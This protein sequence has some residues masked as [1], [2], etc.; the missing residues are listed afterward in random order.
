VVNPEQMGVVRRIF[1]MAGV[2]RTTIYA[3]RRHLEE[4]GLRTPSGKPK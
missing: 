1:R 4:A 3:I 2:Q